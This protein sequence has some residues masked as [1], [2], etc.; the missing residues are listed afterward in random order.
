[1]LGAKAFVAVFTVV[2]TLF[3]GARASNPSLDAAIDNLQ[4]MEQFEAEVTE[5]ALKYGI[6]L[7]DSQAAM[8]HVKMA[9]DA[10]ANDRRV[11]QAALNQPE[12]A[13]TLAS[14]CTLTANASNTKQLNLNCTSNTIRFL[15][16]GDWGEKSAHAGLNAVR[17]AMLAE[18]N[19]IDFIVSAGDNFYTY[20]VSSINDKQWTN[21]W[22]NRYQIGTKLNVPWFSLMGNH[23]HYGNSNAQ[24]EYSKATQPGSKYWI[25][26]GEFYNVDVTNAGGKKMKMVFTDTETIKD[27]DYTWVQ[28]QISDNSTDFVLA[29]GHY[30]V[31]SAGGRGDQTDSAVKRLNTLLQGNSKVKAYICGH[32][33]DMQFLR[34]GNLDY[35]LIG[36]G[37]RTIDF[38]DKSPGTAATINYYARNYGY[39]IYDVDIAARRMNVTYNIYDK[40]GAKVE[41]K[42]FA[43]VF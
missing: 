10:A 24:I 33:H 37:G 38:G 7:E 13:S 39:A 31:Y 3:G 34:S 20:G 11:I 9:T 5:L 26:P 36:G 25:M 32:E 19:N 8:E 6:P 18:A 41:S 29:L 42:V 2:T 15:G 12:S 22:V 16:I 40:K 28:Q 35:Y 23:D 27:A 1:M 21:T 14:R 17:D 30:H 43:R 4:R